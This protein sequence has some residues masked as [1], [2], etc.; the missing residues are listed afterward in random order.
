MKLG[1]LVTTVSCVKLKKRLSRRALRQRG[2]RALT[3][4]HLPTFVI[5]HVFSGKPEANS[6]GMVKTFAV[7]NSGNVIVVS[8]RGTD[9]T[10]TRMV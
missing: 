4:N 5:P 2:S 3:F 7:K 9:F 10:L 6:I 1:E 8:L